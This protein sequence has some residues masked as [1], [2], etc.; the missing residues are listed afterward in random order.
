MNPE[1]ETTVNDIPQ[2]S[3]DADDFSADEPYF[4]PEIPEEM[5]QGMLYYSEKFAFV[6]GHVLSEKF[7]LS[8]LDFG[9]D[10][11]ASAAGIAERVRS[12]LV[13]S[14]LQKL[15]LLAENGDE[16]AAQV[17]VFLEQQY[18]KLW[19]DKTDE[20][21]KE[22][23]QLMASGQIF[24]SSVEKQKLYEPFSFLQ[25]SSFTDEDMQNNPVTRLC[26][27]VAGEFYEEED[28]PQVSAFLMEM[29]G[30][31]LSDY[32]DCFWEE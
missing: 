18:R 13:Y 25:G 32:F 17:S 5:A 8:K 6:A 23:D 4:N 19:K 10:N 29:A 2:E 9:I 30:S 24:L 21:M 22:Y 7:P 28:Q 11:Y 16:W 14:M 15:Q 31:M 27:K 1:N 20:E 26:V 12:F 3:A